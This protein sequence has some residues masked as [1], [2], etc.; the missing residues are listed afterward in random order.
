MD[1]ECCNTYTTSSSGWHWKK[2]DEV[3]KLRKKKNSIKRTLEKRPTVT[4]LS[5]RPPK[6]NP[7][8][9]KSSDIKR[10]EKENKATVLSRN[11]LKVCC[12]T[13]WI[14][15]SCGYRRMKEDSEF[16]YVK[17]KILFY[18]TDYYYQRRY[19]INIFINNLHYYLIL[20]LD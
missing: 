14:E 4:P 7:F 12:C 2:P 16:H 10:L 18:K 9:T 13:Y 15:C 6:P 5:P 17:L 8:K 3:M 1:T 11:L 20:F 19:S